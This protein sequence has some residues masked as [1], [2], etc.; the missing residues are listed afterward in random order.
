MPAAK[1]IRLKD[2]CLSENVGANGDPLQ[3]R[4]QDDRGIRPAQDV[5]SDRGGHIRDY[6]ESGA[7]T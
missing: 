5:Q 3:I 6:V 4:G 2:A 1:T 7:G